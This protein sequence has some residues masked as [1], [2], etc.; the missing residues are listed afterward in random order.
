MAATL[1]IL[2]LVTLGSFLSHLFDID[3]SSLI[4]PA[5]G[6]PSIDHPII[7]INGNGSTTGTT[8]A[9]ASN[10]SNA[11]HLAA[12]TLNVQTLL[13]ILGVGIGLALLTSLIPT[14]FVAHLKP[15]QILRKA[16]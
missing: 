2:L 4:T 15:A 8:S 6:G 10:I 11:A 12:A 13:I 9:T 7:T 3:A 1:A 5:T 16:N 14:W